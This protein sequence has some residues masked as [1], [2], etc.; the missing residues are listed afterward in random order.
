MYNVR[1]IS[2]NIYWVGGNDR[3]LE[4]FENLFPLTNGVSYN[5]Y[6]ILDEKTALI[7]T[8]DDA[9]T[10]QYLENITH[11]MNG[12]ELDYLIINHMEPDHCG[13]IENIV[14]MYPN[15]KVVGNTKSFTLFHQ[16]YN[17]DIT[18]NQMIVKEGDELSLGSHNLKF[19]FAPM[20][21]WPE[22]M[23]NLE[24]TKGILFAADAF[25]TFGALAGNL[26]D[27]EIDYANLYIDEAR[28]YYA[29]IVGKFGAQVQS[30]FKK[31]AG[32]EINMICSLH[33]P[34]FRTDISLILDLYDKWSKYEAEK[35]GV[36][37]FYGS[38][39]GNTANTADALANKL[40]QRGVTDIRVY[41]V[42]K[43]HPSYIIS[44][45]FKYSH[46]VAAAP[47]YNM[48]LYYPM[49]NLLHEMAALGVKNRKVALIGNHSWASAALKIMTE[50]FASM[51]NM[52][53]I[54]DS[55]DIKSRL[56][57]GEEQKLDV[58]ADAIASSVLN[59]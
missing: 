36:V 32:Q 41:D 22:V 55:L 40:A 35:D 3:R 16:F 42:S 27:D 31:I 44:D 43:T 49:D 20:V 7:D 21:H 26:F 11:L 28:R 50:R 12:R 4:Q 52:E 1:E 15:V 57:D 6:L 59:K 2:P 56:K 29:N 8:V 45:I 34:I 5:S 53:I 37:I 14:K 17:M 25:G 13:N 9:I 10:D 51:K 18:A 38:M 48:G 39:Y 33:G 19:V 23:M 46:L 54:G 47:T 58:L 30:V 24:T